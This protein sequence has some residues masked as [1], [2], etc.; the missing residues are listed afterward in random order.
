VDR[1]VQGLEGFQ[2]GWGLGRWVSSYEKCLQGT[3]YFVDLLIISK[4][5]KTKTKTKQ[6]KRPEE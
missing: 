5:K 2:H 1:G 6:N 4:W 3:S